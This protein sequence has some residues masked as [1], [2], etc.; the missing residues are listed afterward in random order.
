MPTTPA[1]AADD[2]PPNIIIIFTDDMGYGDLGSYGHPTID[3]PHLDRMAAEGQRWTSFYSAASVCTPSRAGLLTGR[4]PVRSGMASDRRR[5]LFPDSKGGLPQSE[6][7]IAR[8]LKEVGYATACVGKWHLGHL[9]E[10]LPTSHGFDSYFGI[11]YSNDMD[12]VSGIGGFQ[13]NYPEPEVEYFNV[14]L[15]RDTEIVERPADQTTL[16]RRYTEEVVRKI[17]A[18]QDQPF[19]IYYP[20]TFPHVPLFAGDE[21]Q[22]RS[23]A[24]LYG[25]VIEEIDWSV[26]QIRETLER[27]GLAENT[28]VV[29]TSDNGP[30]LPYRE[31]GGSAGLL[32]AGKGT[33]WEGGMRVP[34]IFW[35]PGRIEPAVVRDIGS[36]LDLFSTALA[37]AGAEMPE[38][39]VFD[40]YDLSPTLLGTGEHPRDEMFYYRGTQ[41]YAVRK[42]PWKAHFVTQGAYQGGAA[43]QE[44]TPPKLYH[45]GRD[46]P[47]RFDQAEDHRDVLK[48]IQTLAD[49]HRSTVSTV[50]SQLERR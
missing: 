6:I 13:S 4:L 22:G 30:W 33:T 25:D 26:G 20:Q 35:W 41:L 46:V 18:Y 10:F 7:T 31:H 43:R 21:F 8:A 44:H 2:R 50:E 12:N 27:L 16:T 23:E 42:G 48:A 9:E 40:G 45:L 19:F 3:T 14:P 34:G 36:T 1:S 39:R 24:G 15:L 11:P 29:F 28:L 17:E 47:E 49:E 37:L 5:V 32:R 38:D